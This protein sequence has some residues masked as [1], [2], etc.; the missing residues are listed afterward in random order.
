MK[1]IACS[2]FHSVP[3]E[4]SLA[5]DRSVAPARR[6]TRLPRAIRARAPHP[7]ADRL[8]AGRGALLA[9]AFAGS[10]CTVTSE[11]FAPGSLDDERD[12]SASGAAQGAAGDRANSSIPT[13]LS[14][15]S[16][17]VVETGEE[18]PT[19]APLAEG[20]PTNAS[21]GA[22]PASEDDAPSDEPP[23]PEITADAGSAQEPPIGSESP[24]N[25]PP[26]VLPELSPLV[27]WASLPGLGLETTTGGGG[28]AT[29]PVVARTAAEL[30]ELAAR[31]EPLTI[32]LVGTIA[33]PALALASNKTLVGI[34]SGATL[35]GG[36]SIRGS[37]DA[38]VENVIVAN[39]NIV[40]PTSTVDGDG[41]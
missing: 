2:P 26:V 7:G 35:L 29:A 4:A 24:V 21:G 14:G 36:I 12:P 25:E 6:C 15:L 5:G 39:L 9:A 23:I 3:V 33:V 18:P 34:G 10:S 20:S 28:G 38:F 37:V 30:V 41:I 8:R 11:N 22:A 40:A 27:G 19:E 31:P 16:P 1:R 17:V 13:P 32:A